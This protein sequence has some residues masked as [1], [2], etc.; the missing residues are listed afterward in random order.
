MTDEPVSWGTRCRQ[1]PSLG[2]AAPPTSGSGGVPDRG[3]GRDRLRAPRHDLESGRQPV[4]SL[5]AAHRP[6]CGQRC[7]CHPGRLGHFACWSGGSCPAGPSCLCRSDCSRLRSS[8]SMR[9]P[10]SGDG[11]IPPGRESRLPH[12]YADSLA[13][14]WDHLGGLRARRH[15]GS[16]MATSSRDL[17]ST[18]PSDTMAARG[19]PRRSPAVERQ[20]GR[21]RR[22][23]YSADRH[24]PLRCFE[25]LGYPFELEWLEGWRGRDRQSGGP[26]SGRSTS[27]P[28]STMSRTRIRPSSSGFP[29]PSPRCSGSA[30]WPPAGLLPG[31]AGR[32][33]AHL[34]LVRRETAMQ[35]P[36]WSPQGF[37]RHVPGQRCLLRPGPGGLTLLGAVAGGGRLVRRRRPGGRALS[38]ASCSSSRSSRNRP[39]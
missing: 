19:W 25:A 29:R 34:A 35:W 20:S 21:R 8:C 30:S 2:A 31:F 10:C 33:G 12:D 26:R 13:W 3:V 4:E 27:H 36:V 32:A 9:T 11:L 1:N 15:R 37:C 38:S 24:L 18:A 6:Q 17:L 16:A 5:P 22:R 28:H 39:H 23:G 7:A 14:S